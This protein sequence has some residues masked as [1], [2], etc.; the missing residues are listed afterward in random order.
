MTPLVGFSW[1]WVLS[2]VP[3]ALV[4]VFVVAGALALLES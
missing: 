4:V 3:I 1:W 2:P